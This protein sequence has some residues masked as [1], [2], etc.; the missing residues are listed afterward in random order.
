MVSRRTMNTITG[1]LYGNHQERCKTAHMHSKNCSKEREFDLADLQTKAFKY[2]V[3][4]QPK[5]TQQKSLLNKKICQASFLPNTGIPKELQ[6]AF[7]EAT[8]F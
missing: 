7:D 6:D 3:L 5:E 1:Y 8:I 2:M 4:Q